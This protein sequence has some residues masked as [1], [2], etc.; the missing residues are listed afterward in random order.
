MLR[1]ITV[2]FVALDLFHARL[3]RPLLGVNSGYQPPSQPP[4]GSNSA[5]QPSGMAYATLALGIASWFL[6]PL[7]GAV[8]GAIIGW[9]ELKNIE[10]GKSPAKGKSITQVGFWLCV[11]HLILSVVGTCAAIAIIVFVFGGFA[12]AM[13]AAG[14]SHAAG[15]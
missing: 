4:G 1:L 10:Q 8:V 6:V 13:S 5:E 9:M 2:V 7:I 12:A 14:L 11:A 3:T 15:H